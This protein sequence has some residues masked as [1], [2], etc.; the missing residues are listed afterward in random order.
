MGDGQDSGSTRGP[1]V[2]VAAIWED[3]PC[4]YFPL[5]EMITLSI[6]TL[7]IYLYLH[8]HGLESR[9]YLGSGTKAP[10]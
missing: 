5:S 6:T 7:I 1:G 10:V 4:H 9:R 2:I 3:E 8:E